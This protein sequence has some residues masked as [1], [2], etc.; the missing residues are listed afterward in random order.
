MPASA[1]SSVVLPA[2]LGPMNPSRFPPR[3]V[4]ETSFTAVNAS[5]STRT[6][7][8]ARTVSGVTDIQQR[9]LRWPRGA[10]KRVQRVIA[11]GVIL[12]YWRRISESNV[13][14]LRDPSPVP[15]DDVYFGVSVNRR[16]YT[17]FPPT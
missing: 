2:P 1:R 5:N 14:S 7:S 11:H 13:I 6:A 4:S 17:G 9:N 12:R 15:Q 8:A 3:S 10:D 16:D